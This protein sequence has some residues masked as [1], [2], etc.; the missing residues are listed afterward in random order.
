MAADAAQAHA[1]RARPA[2]D[3]TARAVP[4]RTATPARRPSRSACRPRRT[5]RC[6]LREH[7]RQRPPQVVVAEAEPVHAGVDLEMTARA[8]TPRAAA[9]AS[10]ARAA[11]GVETVGVRR[12]VNTPS[13]SLTLSAPNTRIGTRDAGIAQ[14]HAFF[15]VR[16]REH[17]R[18]GRLE[19]RADRRRAVAVRV[20]L[21]DG[22][23]RR[24]GV[25]APRFARPSRSTQ[26]ANRARG[27][28]GSRRGSTRGDR[29]PDHARPIGQYAG[30]RR[31]GSRSACTA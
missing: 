7:L 13:R 21:D 23:D 31:R 24:V 9:A 27:W 17:R 2:R 12:C 30:T 3:R 14:R 1:R 11:P 8:S 10:S 20:R 6:G 22:D 4:R 15:D 26:R 5:A 18:A 29:R 16:A 19:R 25:P 28:P